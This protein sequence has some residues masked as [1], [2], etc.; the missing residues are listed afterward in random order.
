MS[1]PALGFG[2]A[3]V[4]GRIGR[5]ESQRALDLAHALG[6]R[7]F[8]TARSYGWGE[9]EGVLG[10]FLAAKPRDQVTL[11]TK[12]GILPV[13]QSGALSLAK[14]AARQALRLV[15][16]ASALVRRAASTPALQPTRSYDVAVLR[17]SLEAS[18]SRLGTDHVDVLLLHNYALHQAGLGDVMGLFQDLAREG[19]LRRY[20]VSIEGPLEESLAHLDREGA[21]PQAVVQAPLTPALLAAL[22]ARPDVTFIAHSPFRAAL[23]AA[24]GEQLRT[25][26]HALAGTGQCRALVAS[27]FSPGHIEANVRDHAAAAQ[28]A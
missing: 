3:P 2:T 4:L 10:E 6:V 28:A 11:V 17:A 13:R 27:M 25:A 12:C 21:L 26:L 14:A 22:A 19:K 16:S 1:V 18:L 15:P 24:P 23:G 8:D 9:A 20:G 7:H 5:K